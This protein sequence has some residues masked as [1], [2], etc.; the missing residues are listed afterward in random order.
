MAANLKSLVAKINDA[1]RNALES[2]ASLALS[3]THYDVEIEHYLLRL[4]ET[5]DTDAEKIFHHFS[6]DPMRLT[7]DLNKLLD[8]MKRGNGRSPALSPLIAKMLSEAWVLGSL[9]QNQS[10]IRT[11]FTLL[12]LLTHRCV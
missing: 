2:A 5:T 11:G 10:K 7:A 12:A 6:I 9:E 8:K 1:T 4:L 3:R